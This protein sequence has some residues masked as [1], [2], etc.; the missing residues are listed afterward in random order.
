MED[1]ELV[2]RPSS[3]PPTRLPTSYR[4]NADRV[5]I[6][7]IASIVASCTLSI[8]EKRGIIPLQLELL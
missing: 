5:M 2:L 6:V 7:I 3:D 8:L 1:T 4:I